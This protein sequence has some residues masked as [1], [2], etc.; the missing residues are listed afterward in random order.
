MGRIKS[1]LCAIDFS[2]CS[3]EITDY[4]RELA[5]SLN[6]S[7]VVVYAAQSLNRYMLFNVAETAVKDFT[8][9]M[10]AG[11]SERMDKLLEETFGDVEAKGVVETGYPAEVILRAASEND[12]DLI[13]MGTHGR[14]GWDR[15]VFGSVAE[16][17]VKASKIPVM[18]VPPKDG[19]R[20]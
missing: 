10:V 4:V 7:V 8:D 5:E 9:T 12:C 20:E 2:D 11:A 1:I 14:S 16:K 19:G 3:P 13:V 15:I 17:V 18:T 6:A